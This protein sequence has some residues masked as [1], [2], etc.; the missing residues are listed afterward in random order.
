MLVSSA[1]KLKAKL[2][3]KGK[4]RPHAMVK[5]KMPDGI[6]ALVDVPK[7]GAGAAAD[8]TYCAAIDNIASVLARQRRSETTAA[9][10]RMYMRLFDGWLVRSGFG[11]YVEVEVDAHGVLNSYLRAAT[12]CGRA[13]RRG[14]QRRR[15][16]ATT[17]A[18]R[19]R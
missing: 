2:Q 18:A 12:T 4:R 16:A 6:D 1:Q 3:V 10:H 19:R 5:K 8:E 13:R 7:R 14:R 9:E 17:G 11:S 15:R